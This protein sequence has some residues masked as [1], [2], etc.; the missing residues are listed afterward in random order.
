M[1]RLFAHFRSRFHQ[2]HHVIWEFLAVVVVKEMEGIEVS[3]LDCAVQ[4]HMPLG[5]G[6]VWPTESE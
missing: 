4:S 1:H 6:M 2:C 3:N 5:S